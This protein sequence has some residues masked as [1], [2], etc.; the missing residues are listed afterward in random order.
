[1]S[2]LP[3]LG[4]AFSFHGELPKRNRYFFLSSEGPTF[5]ILNFLWPLIGKLFSMF[6]FSNSICF[7]NFQDF[8]I[9]KKLL[10]VLIFDV[11]TLFLFSTF[12]CFSFTFFSTFSFLRDSA[13]TKFYFLHISFFLYF[14]FIFCFSLLIQKLLSLLLFSFIFKC[15]SFHKHK[16]SLL[17]AFLLV[18]TFWALL[19]GQNV[20]KTRKFKILYFII[21][22]G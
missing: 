14:L 8:C 18:L 21:F 12:P 9:F 13:L 5:L 7:F 10:Y 4:L 17:T 22:Y 20:A 6:F 16:I 1:M 15:V 3:D 19:G 11:R 2:C